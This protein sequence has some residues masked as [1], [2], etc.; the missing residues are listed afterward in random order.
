ML[1][2][3]Q[4]GPS[5]QISGAWAANLSGFAILGALFAIQFDRI[6][7][8]MTTATVRALVGATALLAF[9]SFASAAC[10][11]GYRWNE[12]VGGKT[13][14]HYSQQPPEGRQ[15]ECVQVT[16]GTRSLV[17]PGEAPAETSGSKPASGGQANA[18]PANKPKGMQGVPDKDP[19]KCKEAQDAKSV[20]DSHARIREKGDNGEYRYLTPDEIGEQKK[21]AD[22]TIGVYCE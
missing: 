3:P 1:T 8:T 11:G 20:L 12:T 17:N 15:S 4:T 19:A 14:T 2:A 9:S 6:D 5:Q 7:I 18:A 16:T 13:I 10:T 22:E 21:L